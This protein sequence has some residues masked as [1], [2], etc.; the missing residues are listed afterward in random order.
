MVQLSVVI[1][2]TLSILE[3]VIFDVVKRSRKLACQLLPDIVD[4]FLL[5]KQFSLQLGDMLPHALDLVL[6]TQVELEKFTA[7][8]VRPFK[9]LIQI[10]DNL[11]LFRYSSSVPPQPS[12]HCVYVLDFFCLKYPRILLQ[13]LIDGFFSCQDNLGQLAEELFPLLLSLFTWNSAFFG[14]V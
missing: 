13:Q 7:L 5:L 2:L 11:V 10:F 14:H 12:L 1:E 3:V 8:F 6:F 9:L 4:L